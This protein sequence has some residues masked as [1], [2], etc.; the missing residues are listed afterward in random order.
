MD[1]LYGRAG[2]IA[3][4]AVLLSDPEYV[5]H[6]DHVGNCDLWCA[7]P[8]QFVCGLRTLSADHESI[9]C[10]PLAALYQRDPTLHDYFPIV[11]PAGPVGSFAPYGY[12]DLA[13]QYPAVGVYQRGV[14]AQRILT[15]T[16]LAYVAQ[17]EIASLRVPA[18]GRDLLDLDRINRVQQR[19]CDGLLPT[20]F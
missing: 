4:S 19:A 17:A 15:I 13:V 18:T 6:A 1:E 14:C 20:L 3:H 16:L 7:A 9:D 10:L 5:R 2:S 12:A 8:A 11:H